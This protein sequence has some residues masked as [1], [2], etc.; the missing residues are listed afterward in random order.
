MKMECIV[1][2]SGE[3]GSYFKDGEWVYNYEV[4]FDE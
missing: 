1:T 3:P 4:V 2:A